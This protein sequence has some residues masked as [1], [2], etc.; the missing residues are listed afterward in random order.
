MKIA[1]MQPYIFPYIGY[2]HLIHAADKFV[3]LD[4][5]AF[6]N[7]GWINRNRI[8][9]T[10][11]KSDYLFTIPLDNASQNKKINEIRIH[12]NYLKWRDS[13]K[14]TFEIAYSDAPYSEQ[15]KTIVFGL[16]DRTKPGDQIS[17]VTRNSIK[18]CADY[19]GL[20]RDWIDSSSKY[21][22]QELRKGVRLIDICKQENAEHYINAIG[23]QELYTPDVFAKDG[24]KLSFVKSELNSYREPFLKGLSILDLIAYCDKETLQ[25]QLS[26]YNLV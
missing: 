16:L 24:I 22:N 19:L 9:S 23:G 18:L 1:V 26:S 10:D 3:F 21:N 13:F 12:T 2:F 5:V 17:D 7:R 6:I 11:K 4:D 8:L 25:Q 15:A 14:K 20:K